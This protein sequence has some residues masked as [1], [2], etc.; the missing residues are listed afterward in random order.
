MVGVKGTITTIKNQNSKRTH[1]VD[2]NAVKDRI[3]I[4][5]QNQMPSAIKMIM[6]Q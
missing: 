1:V 6:G 3:K 4:R 2:T 5:F